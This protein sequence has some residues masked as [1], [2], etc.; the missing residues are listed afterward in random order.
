MFF[1]PHLI[2]LYQSSNKSSWTRDLHWFTRIGITSPWLAFADL[3]LDNYQVFLWLTKL[4]SRQEEDSDNELGFLLKILDAWRLLTF[5]GNGSKASLRS[6]NPTT[7]PTLVAWPKEYELVCKI[8]H[9]LSDCIFAIL[10]IRKFI[11]FRSFLSL[12][13]EKFNYWVWSL[14]S[15]WKVPVYGQDTQRKIFLADLF[16]PNSPN[17]PPWAG[18]AH[19]FSVKTT[20]LTRAKPVQRQIGYIHLRVCIWKKESA[21]AALLNILRPQVHSFD[22]LTLIRCDFEA[23]RH[24][25][26]PK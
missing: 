16:T 11:S 19:Q 20:F 18:L 3:T 9:P 4:S 7:V 23:S 15:S 13:L 22:W 1:Q 25:P 10:V 17:Q 8:R 26:A 14:L 21:A 24:I 5:S 6:F 2:I 12:S